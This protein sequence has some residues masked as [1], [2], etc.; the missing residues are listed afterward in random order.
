MGTTI[1]QAGSDDTLALAELASATFP[2][3]CPPG[4]TPEDIATF[5]AANL[6]AGCFARYLDDPSRA[7]FVAAEHGPAAGGGPG[8]SAQGG[9]HLVGYTMVVDVPPSDADVAAA[10]GDGAAVE[11]SKCYARPDVHGTGVTAC[12]MA[13]CLGWAAGRGAKQVWLGVNSE[14]FRAR[15]FY[16]KHGFRVAGSKD[17]QLGDRVEHDHV[18]VRPV[19]S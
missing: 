8:G 7:L 13:A 9:A 12:L 19:Q 10:V 11:L 15:R 1:R 16:E 3:A 2:L 4:S 14:N 17:F 5:I 6:N 18:M